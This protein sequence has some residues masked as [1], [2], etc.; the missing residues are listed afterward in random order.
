MGRVPR[1][2]IAQND[3]FQ[4]SVKFF[5]TFLKAQNRL[6]EGP[7]DQLGHWRMSFGHGEQDGKGPR[8]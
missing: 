7:R 4:K 3:E 6:K 2:E 5:W 8:A 1:L